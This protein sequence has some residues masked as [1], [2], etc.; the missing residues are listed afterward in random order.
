MR[1]A[2]TVA[3]WIDMLDLGPQPRPGGAAAADMR[4]HRLDPPRSLRT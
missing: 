2:S 4:G 1:Y 3:G